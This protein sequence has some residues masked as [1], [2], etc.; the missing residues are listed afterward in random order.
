VFADM[1]QERGLGAKNT[2]TEHNGS[3]LGAPCETMVEGDGGRWWGRTNEV[4][5]VVGLRVRKRKV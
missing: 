2:E 4:V 3:I 1:R 5:V